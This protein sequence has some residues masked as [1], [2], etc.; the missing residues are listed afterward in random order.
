[1]FRSLAPALNAGEL[2][3]ETIAAQVTW[4]RG[5]LALG[6]AMHH[7]V[8]DGRSVWRFVGARSAATLSSSAGRRGSTS[9]L[10]PSP[11]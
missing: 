9:S 11:R 5:G 10:R 3:A 1:M 6:V 8:V 7:T 4:L 2:P